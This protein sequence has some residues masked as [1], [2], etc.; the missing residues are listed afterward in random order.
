VTELIES[1]ESEGN[2]MRAYK[3]YLTIKDP[4]RVVLSDVPFRPGEHVEVVM[5]ATD[6]SLSAHIKGLQALFKKTQGLPQA[7]TITEEDIAAEIEAY[8]RGK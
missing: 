3:D 1:Q 7:E 8:R 4:K 5:L 2:T 6:D